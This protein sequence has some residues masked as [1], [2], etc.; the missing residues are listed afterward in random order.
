MKATMKM[1]RVA[2][3]TD[4]FV[5]QEWLVQVGQVVAEGDS[6]LSVETDKAVV[7]VP[8][9]VAGTVLELLVPE[10]SEVTTG[11]PIAVFEVT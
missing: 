7:S 6:L 8:A 9:P 2:D 4:T 3:S 1:P 10:E 11:Q 5:V